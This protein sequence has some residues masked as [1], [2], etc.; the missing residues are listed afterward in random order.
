MTPALDFKYRII[1]ESL[2]RFSSALSR[3][4][5][6]EE[7]KQC[8]QSQVKYL[9]DYQLIRFCFYHA[10]CY[11]IY[12]LIPSQC[13]FQC[14]DARLLGEYERVLKD[15]HVPL[16]IE[17]PD[18]F[19]PSLAAFPLHLATPPT[20]V[21]GW[22]VEFTPRSGLLVSVASNPARQFQPTDVPVLKI[23]LENLYAKLL[24]LSLFDEL[25][26]SKKA[27]ED[28]LLGVQQKNSEIAR[29]VAQQEA[30]IQHRTQELTT[31]NAQLLNLYREHAH[32]IREPVARI[33]SLTYLIQDLPL[34]EVV[35]ELIPALL[36][37]STD[38]DVALRGVVDR[39]DTEL[40]FS[41]GNLP[42]P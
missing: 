21:W 24:A 2:S 8:L 42:L 28:A 32:T 12:T 27:V 5:T 4:T 34:E 16:I 37:T 38:L 29:L 40:V 31:K 41:P 39:I 14:G 15:Q 18:L 25:I 13:V 23:A 22:N 36:T 33:L 26:A 20:Q 9:F 3:S 10:E 19:R 35:N 7:V 30:I 6:L 1:Y 11:T 17:E